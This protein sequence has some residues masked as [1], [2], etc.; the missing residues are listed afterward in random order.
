MGS[1]TKFTGKFTVYQNLSEDIEDSFRKEVGYYGCDSK[2]LQIKRTQDQTLITVYDEWKNMDEV[3]FVNSILQ[4]FYQRGIVVTGGINCLHEY[5]D[6]YR[7]EIRKDEVYQL[8]AK[9]SYHR[10]RKMTKNRLKARAK[11]KYESICQVM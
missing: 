8:A 2:P 5:G 4:F 6:Q 11:A 3:V 10:P 9:I 1:Y 7:V